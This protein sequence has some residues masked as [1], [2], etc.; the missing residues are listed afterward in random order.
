MSDIALL[1]AVVLLLVVLSALLS[2]FETLG[3]WAGWDRRWPGPVAPPDAPAPPLSEGTT[4]TARY[5]LVYLS[6]VGSFGPKLLIE[7]ELNFLDLLRRRLPG[8]LI[9]R[10]IYPY[11]PTNDPLSGRRYLAPFWR[12]I[13]RLMEASGV[14]LL[15]LIISLRNLFQV[16]ISADRRYGPLFNFGVAREI[17]LALV[18][19]GYRL[20]DRQPVVLM[21]LSG[22]AQIAVGCTPVL[23]RLLHAPI[24]LVSI[25]GVLTDDPGIL[26]VEH[27]LHL[28]GSRDPVQHVGAWLY[29]GRW[30]VF[31]RSAW[32]RALA[33]GKLTVVDVGPVRH[34]AQGDYFS[35]SAKLPTGQSY[36]EKTVAVIGDYVQSLAP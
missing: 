1:V 16:A 21:G 3:W 17:A 2:P 5:Y 23:R 10:D 24:W 13:H 25:G 33:R 4:A 26:M 20:G 36:V 31:K 9:V 22:A 29:P 7:K 8:A 14:T 6:G 28:S 15:V 27:V 18:R 30:P 12:L 35:R 32:N 19:S 34:M 11:S